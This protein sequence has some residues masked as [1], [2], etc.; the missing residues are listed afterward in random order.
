VGVGVFWELLE[1]AARDVGERFD[2]EPV[3]VHYGWRDTVFDLG[4]DAVGA[5]VVVAVDLRLFV[6]ILA[7][8]PTI[9]DAILLWSTVVVC[10]GSL[11]LA[12]GVRLL[13]SG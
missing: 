10:V 3:L 11:L 12:G 1:L 9:V 8:I 2:V 7:R 13:G 4:F 6:S 5:V